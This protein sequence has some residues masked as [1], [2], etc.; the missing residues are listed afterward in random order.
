MVS[1][2]NVTVE[3]VAKVV[4]DATGFPV[5]RLKSTEQEKVLDL[6]VVLAA[7]VRFSWYSFCVSVFDRS[8]GRGPTG[9]Y[10]GCCQRDT[11][12]L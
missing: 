11:T 12:G 6:G 3:V 9:S 1:P 10:A 5:D 2:M 8:A 4:S 7:E